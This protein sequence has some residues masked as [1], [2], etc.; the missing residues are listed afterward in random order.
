MQSRTIAF[1]FILLYLLASCG[2][3][4]E[5]VQT[6]TIGAIFPLTG[7]RADAGEY[8]RNGIELALSKINSDITRHYKLKCTVT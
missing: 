6:V 7:T 8:L 1:C 3:Y 2:N 4:S 5:N